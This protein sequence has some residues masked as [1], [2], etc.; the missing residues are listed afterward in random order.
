[1]TEKTGNSKYGTETLEIISE[2]DNFNRWM[3]EKIK[4]HCKGEILEIGS[5]IGNMSQYFIEDGANL[6]LSDIEESYFPRLQK[7]IG[8]RENLKG[9]YQLDFS[10]KDLE[11]N[12]PELIGQFDTVFALNVV[13]HIPDH[14]Q[15]LKNAHKL[16]RKGGKVVILVPAFQSLFNQFDEQLDH[17][18]RY[19]T[20]TLK[21]LIEGNGFKVKHSE[22]F[23]FIGMLGWIIS[24]K[25]LRKKM[26]PEGQ[27]KIYN[28][29]VPLWKIIDFFTRRF[30][31]ISI[32][33][34][35]EKI[36]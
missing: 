31:G 10:D 12:H 9:M 30:V 29:L 7:K 15:A 22:F 2:A 32:I 24:G 21:F 11:K 16:L 25:V 35:G 34:V 27:M 13:E 20:N 18:R 33:Q 28:S 5:G 17:Q 6:T 3:F 14:E 8:K 36:N 19:T 1:M 4:P 26:I 23:N